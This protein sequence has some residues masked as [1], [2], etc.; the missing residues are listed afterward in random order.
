MRELEAAEGLVTELV[1]ERIELSELADMQRELDKANSEKESLLQQ[2]REVTLDPLAAIRHSQK[3]ISGLQAERVASNVSALNSLIEATPLAN[4]NVN[5][6]NFIANY[7]EKG[8]LRASL[9]T[10][11]AG[12]AGGALGGGQD[13]QL[14]GRP[15]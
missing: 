7:E 3:T 14:G 6:R 5:L 10:S 9:T 2:L 4:T 1:A 13:S 8:N 15:S 12:A 11:H